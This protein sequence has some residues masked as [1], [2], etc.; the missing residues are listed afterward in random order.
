MHLTGMATVDDRMLI[1]LD[2]ARLLT[3]EELVARERVLVA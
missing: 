2:M 3:D 1:M